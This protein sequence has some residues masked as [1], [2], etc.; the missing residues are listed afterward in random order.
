MS[1]QRA[2]KP[3]QKQERRA[4]ILDSAAALLR[5]KGLDGASL[6]RIARRAGIAKSGVY[7]Y[8]ESR[9]E[10]FLHLFRDDL[11]ELVDWAEPALLPLAGSNDV[12]AVAALVAEGF[13]TRPRL[14]ELNAAVASVLEQ[15]VSEETVLEF[16]TD[17][18]GQALRLGA[19]LHEALPAIGFDDLASSFGPMYALVGGLWPHHDPPPAVAAV[20]ARPE[21]EVMRPDFRRDLDHGLTLMLRGLLAR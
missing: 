4:D 13:A 3:E 7:N 17:I 10:I 9:E 11:T 6:N 1:F 5:E 15:N 16:K 8:F 20:L 19:A 2:R 18:F 12:P 14:C 21:F